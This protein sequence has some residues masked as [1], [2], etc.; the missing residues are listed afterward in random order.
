MV[1]IPSI[2]D[3]LGVSVRGRNVIPAQTRRGATVE[4]VQNPTRDQLLRLTKP[5]RGRPA[6]ETDSLRFI[7][8]E[9]GNLFVAPAYGFTHDDMARALGERL[10]GRYEHETRP[11]E[12]HGGFMSTGYLRRRGDELVEE[13]ANN[14]P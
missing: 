14:D 2:P 7:R 4:I 5:N 11:G 12:G 1:R 8:D 9:D 13:P 6:H 10:R 3:V